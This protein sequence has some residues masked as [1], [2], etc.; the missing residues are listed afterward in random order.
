MPFHPLLIVPDNIKTSMLNICALAPS[1]PSRI[2]ADTLTPLDSQQPR[3]PAILQISKS[4]QQIQ[5]ESGSYR[6]N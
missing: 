6:V 4:R 5:L 3:L 1:L 2:N